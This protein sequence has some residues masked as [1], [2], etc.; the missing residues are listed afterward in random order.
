MTGFK[1]TGHILWKIC[2]E[3]F[4]SLIYRGYIN[5]SGKKSWPV[6]KLGDGQKHKIYHT[7]Q[8]ISQYEIQLHLGRLPSVLGIVLVQ[9]M[10]SYFWITILE[11]PYK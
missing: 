8:T 7:I 2:Y 4:L 6:T 1:L 10:V 11:C 5:I 9:I 3:L